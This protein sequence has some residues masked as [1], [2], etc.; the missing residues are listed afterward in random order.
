MSDH[1]DR[2]TRG[3]PTRLNALKTG[4]ALLL[5]ATA[6]TGCQAQAMGADGGDADAPPTPDVAVIALNRLAFGPRPGDLDA[7]RS[8]PGAT[9]RDKLRAY[10]EG[11]LAPL[12]I[13][14]RAC[15]ARVSA[16]KLPSLG[17]SLERCWIDYYTSLNPHDPKLFQKQYQPLWEA[18]KATLIR[19]VY[20]RRQL[21]E[22]LAD[23]WHNHFNT[24]PDHSNYAVFVQYDRDVIRPHALGNFRALLEAVATSPEMLYYLDNAASSRGGPNENYARELFELHTLGADNYLGVGRQRAVA[25]YD[26]GAPVGY[27]DD[28][29]YEASRCFTGWR[30][31]DTIDDPG[32]QNT[33][34]F[35]YYADWHDRF[36]KTVLGRFFPPDGPDMADGRGVLDLLAAHPGTARSIA[37]KLCRRLVAD[38]P[39]ESL[40]QEAARVFAAGLHA[41]DQ[42]ARVV[43]AI[44]LSDEFASAWGHKIKCPF[45]A[46]ASGLR[47]LDARLTP[48]D[49]FVY[50]YEAMGQPLFGRPS[51][52]GYPDTRSLWSGAA[53]MLARWNLAVDLTHGNVV[54]VTADMVGQ[55][56]SSLRA[57]A[58]IADYWIARLLGRPMYPADGR[59]AVVEA[60]AQGGKPDAPLSR[61]ALTAALPNAVALIMMAPDFHWR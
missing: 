29:V 23:F 28:D 1:P 50:Y 8:L 13:D 6:L 19:A 17:K 5:G 46:M 42:I 2:S 49:D 48:T 56:P 11:Q 41:P 37:R 51:P 43:R 3:H 60:L 45:E 58:H 7:F 38:A 27:V 25:G 33:G 59:D 4:G 12:R 53:V 40:V 16:A 30:V 18:K 61:D 39:P 26:E 52:D 21:H 44:V 57:P 36:Q 31:N 20:S 24:D 54:G 34:A 10:V 22:V 32:V 14:D 9:P 15:D 35:R 55:T 47:A